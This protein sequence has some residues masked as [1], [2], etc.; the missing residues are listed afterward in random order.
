METTRTTRRCLVHVAAEYLEDWLRE[1]GATV[2]SSCWQAF[3]VV[4]WAEAVSAAQVSA[5]PLCRYALPIELEWA[6]WPRK[7]LRVEEAVG[8]LRQAFG[9]QEVAQV[10]VAA[11]HG[12]MRGWCAPLEAALA[13]GFGVMGGEDT[14]PRAAALVVALH[15]DRLW[16]GVVSPRDAGAWQACAA[17]PLMWLAAQPSP[18]ISRAAVKWLEARDHL[19]RRGVDPSAPRRW[20]ELGA[21]PGGITE[22]LLATDAGSRVTAVDVAPLH[23]RLAGHPRLTFARGDVARF[24]LGA[25]ERFDGV[26]CDV[27]G[28]PGVAL[29]ATARLIEGHLS[30]SGVVVFTLKVPRWSGAGALLAQARARLAAAG[31]E[32]EARHLVANRQ[33]LTL[34]GVRC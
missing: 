9:G 4:E 26:V 25:S 15:A 8:A 20:L 28:A 19:R 1:A 11:T 7:K 27:N 31:V 34:I 32:V 6:V 33:E 24:A 30:P 3:H 22:G 17:A 16:A 21:A 23:P 29:E 5:H 2:V 12:A 18:W 13:Q 10:R 14:D